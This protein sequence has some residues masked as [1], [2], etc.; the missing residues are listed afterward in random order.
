[1]SE[2][3]LVIDCHQC[4]LYDTD[5][6]SDCVVTFLCRSDVATPVVV[7]LAEVRA[8]KMLD[9]AGLVPPLRHR[10]AAAGST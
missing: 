1:M 8:M 9:V 6:C 7:D 4:A 3:P 10:S 2:T 5:A